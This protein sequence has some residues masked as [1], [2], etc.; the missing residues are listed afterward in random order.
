MENVF[1]PEELNQTFEAS[2]GNIPHTYTADE[3]ALLLGA[4][5]GL[6]ASII[7][8]LKNV[9]KSSCCLGLIKIE[10]RTELPQSKESIIQQSEV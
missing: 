9:K 3:I 4:L 2:I 5:G 8:G 6:I 1:G 10:Q 7:Y